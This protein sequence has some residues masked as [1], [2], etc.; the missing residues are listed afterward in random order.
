MKSRADGL[1]SVFMFVL[2]VSLLRA[3]PTLLVPALA[4]AAR[5]LE[6]TASAAAAADPLVSGD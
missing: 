2:F 4:P 6:K 3:A 1:V 5:L